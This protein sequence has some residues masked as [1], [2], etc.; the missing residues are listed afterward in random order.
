M[1]EQNGLSA[2]SLAIIFFAARNISVQSPIGKVL[3]G[4]L[5]LHETLS[6]ALLIGR[7]VKSR[8]WMDTDYESDR[9]ISIV[10][11]FVN[12]F[13]LLCGAGVLRR[14]SIQRAIP[15]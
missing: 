11:L 13:C 8:G 7:I 3:V 4:T 12:L 10:L 15:I 6:V 5:L 9:D 14:T 2:A 1:I